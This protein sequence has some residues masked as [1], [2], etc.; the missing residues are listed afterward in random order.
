MNAL[1]PLPLD[2]ADSTDE[3]LDGYDYPD[4]S[5]RPWWLRANMLSTVDGAV[6]GPD[7]RSGSLG[8][9]ADRLVFRRLRVLADAIVVGAGTARAENYGP[10]RPDDATQ[11]KRLEA[12]LSP[13]P[14]LVIL[15]RTLALDPSSRLFSGPDRVMIVTSRDADWRKVDQLGEK[16]DVVRVGAPE[17]DLPGLL[18]LLADQGLRRLLCEGGPRLLGHLLEHALLDEICLTVVPMLAGGDGTRVT[19]SPLLQPPLSLSLASLARSAD[20]TLLTRWVRS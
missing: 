3:V 15:T 11:Q 9:P 5:G 17:I 10:P 7:G 2:A 18:G 14:R 19:A 16:A 12:G 20:G 4:L 13:R 6:V 1:H 8:T